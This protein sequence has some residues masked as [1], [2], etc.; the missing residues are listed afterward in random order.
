M[1]PFILA[2]MVGEGI[3]IYRAMKQPGNGQTTVG[4]KT[5]LVPPSPVQLLFSSSVFVMLALLA[6]VPSA[7][8]LAIT[9]AWGFD[10][11]AYMK[12]F[13]KV[14]GLK[15]ERGPWPPSIA[16]SNVITPTGGWTNGQARKLSDNATT[17]PTTGL[18]TV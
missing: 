11:A 18:R 1:G 8:T 9:L 3:V 5:V 15:G 2:W 6:E 17:P 7:R 13:D 16:P 10:I 14:S 4:G 12:L